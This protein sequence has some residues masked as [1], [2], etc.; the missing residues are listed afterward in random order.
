[1][2]KQTETIQELGGFLR[3]PQVLAIFPVGKSTW[4]QGIK[5]G[6]YPKPV[7]LSERIVAWRLRDIHQLIQAAE[8]CDGN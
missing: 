3:L 6:K 2:S 8:H 7:K 5:D 1:M 4:W